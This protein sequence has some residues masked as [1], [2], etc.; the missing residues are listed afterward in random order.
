[1]KLAQ[2]F[3]LAKARVKELES[4]VKVRVD[5]EGPID[6]GK[7]KV[8]GYVPSE[9][10]SNTNPQG[11]ITSMISNGVPKDGIWKEIGLSKT[12][13]G[14]LL[15]ASGLKDRLDELLDEFGE[16]KIVTSLREHKPG[17]AGGDE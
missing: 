12:A 6:L 4:A 13:V 8:L 10:W 16:K 3:A 14:K 15:R 1:L 2:E 17:Q 9:R 5:A 11:L 7:G